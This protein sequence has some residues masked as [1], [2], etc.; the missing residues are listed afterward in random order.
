MIIVVI[1]DFIIIPLL[2]KYPIKYP[3]HS[4]NIYIYVSDYTSMTPAPST[5]ANS[6]RRPLQAPGSPSASGRGPQNYRKTR[7]KP[8]ENHGKI[9]GKPWENHGK[10]IG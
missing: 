7:G 1:I 8:W 6:L 2:A 3:I 9:I 5:A 4:N 10:I